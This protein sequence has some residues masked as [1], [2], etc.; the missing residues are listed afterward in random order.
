MVVSHID[1]EGRLALPPEILAA[2]GISPNADVEISVEAGTLRVR[3][4]LDPQSITAR[5]AAMDLPV[6]T[7]DV[8]KREIAAGRRS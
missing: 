7:W 3:P 4:K 1:A 8:M 6:D 5:I 2:L